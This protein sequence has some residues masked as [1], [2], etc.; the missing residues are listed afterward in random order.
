MKWLPL[1]SQIKKIAS[2]FGD[3]VCDDGQHFVN[4]TTVKLS[5][6]VQKCIEQNSWLDSKI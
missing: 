2:D 5:H 6:H 3:K 1:I 4:M